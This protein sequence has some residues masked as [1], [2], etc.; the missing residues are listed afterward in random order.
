MAKMVLMCPSHRDVP[1]FLH[2]VIE[3]RL[4]KPKVY[5]HKRPSIITPHHFP[6]AVLSFK[7]NVL[8]LPS[9]PPVH[10]NRYRHHGANRSFVEERIEI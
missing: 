3:L 5:A 7:I 8:L 1:G 4:N 9:Q 6:S 2:P 10:T